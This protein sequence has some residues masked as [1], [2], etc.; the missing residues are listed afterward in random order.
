MEFNCALCEVHT[1]KTNSI[2]SFI[3]KFHS[4]SFFSEEAIRRLTA[5]VSTNLSALLDVKLFY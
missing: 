4:K 5:V 2:F 1:F 3:I